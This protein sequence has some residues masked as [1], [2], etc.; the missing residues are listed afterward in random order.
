MR[1]LK[2]AVSVV[3]LVSIIP[4][5]QSGRVLAAGDVTADGLDAGGPSPCE[6]CQ[7]PNAT[8]ACVGDVCVISSCDPGFSDCDGLE[9]NG[10][11]TPTDALP[12][13]GEC[14]Q[15]CDDGSDCTDDIC[16]GGECRH[17]D[18]S[19]CANPAC[20]SSAACP[21]PDSDGDG[22]NDT[23][24]QN[25]FI[26]MDCNQV[27]DSDDVALP[28]ADPLVKDIYLEIDYMDKAL[29]EPFS[30][31]PCPEALE[32]VIDAF[33]VEGIRLHIDL[34][35]EPLPHV[36]VLTFGPPPGCAGPDA[37]DLY[38]L[39]ASHFDPK[40]ALFAH[41]CVFGHSTTCDSDS[42]CADCAAELGI[43]IKPGASGLAEV[44]GNDFV[45]SIGAL[46]YM[47]VRE[48]APDAFVRIEAGTLAHE[49]GHNLGLCHDG[50]GE[51]AQP[52]TTPNHLSVMNHNY[53]FAG[54]SSAATP[55]SIV[56][57]GAPRVDFSNGEFSQQA[58]DENNLDESLGVS[59]T[60]AWTLDIVTYYCGDG[61]VV[62][63]AGCGPIDWNC[64][65]PDTERGVV[66]D[67]NGDGVLS[68]ALADF[69][70]W[71]NL[72]LDFQCEP[73][74]LDGPPPPSLLSSNELD[75]E[76]ARQRMVLFPILVPRV[77]VRPLCGTN[78]IFL[79]SRFPLPVA[80]LGSAEL[81]VTRVVPSSLRFA[82][83][84]PL[85]TAQ[86]D[87]DGDGRIDLLALFLPADL[88]LTPLSTSAMLAG[89]LDSSQAFAGK[90]SVAVFSSP[91]PRKPSV[92]P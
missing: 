55:G 58:L 78:R 90:D 71:A 70:D 12:N 75:F 86:V 52:P 40:K 65:S 56:P 62:P 68:P 84:L 80:L 32:M 26:D 59:G 11:E 87:I 39:K 33:A 6:G 91:G 47:A 4:G 50:P 76:T 24:E 7:L 89:H 9:S 31:K 15:T 17:V 1:A 54:I 41:W 67:I 46:G 69:D 10:C 2:V 14:G 28:G 61:L 35:T 49:L 73:T 19:A 92:C 38:A 44:N 8:A 37:V 29:D 34:A 25:G 43:Q 45:V 20:S 3:V 85:G 30:H 57:S 64:I 13:C 79:G 66:A 21:I 23:W 22:L 36:T 88:N 48:N 74:F 81:D 16:V 27:F 51:C 42:N 63:G 77:D 5:V 82:G 60:S 83:A 53:Q 72:K 18:R